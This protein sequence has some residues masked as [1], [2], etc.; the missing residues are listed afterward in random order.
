MS[1]VVTAET[2][3][4]RDHEPVASN[5][6][7]KVQL[8]RGLMWWSSYLLATCLFVIL[9]L[10]A[11]LRIAYADPDHYWHNRFLFISPNAYRNFDDNFWTYRPDVTIREVGIYGVAALFSTKPKILVEYDCRMRSNNLGLLQADNIQRGTV[12][13]VVMGD[14]FAAGQGGCP[15]FDRLQARRKS[16]RLINA[17]LPGTGFG[18]WVR[19]L[20]YLRGESVTVQRILVIAISSDFSRGIWVWPKPQ[21]ECL[22]QVL[23]PEDDQP[24][25]WL[26]VEDQE[27]HFRLIERSAARFS[28]RFA[29]S[30]RAKAWKEYLRQEFYLAKFVARAVDNVREHGA[31]LRNRE[32][33]S[34]ADRAL[35]GFKSLGIPL[36]VMLVSQRDEVGPFGNRQALN[37]AMGVL[38]THGV[39]HSWCRLSKGHFLPFDGHPNSTGYDYLSGC[40]DQILDTLN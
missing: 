12:A 14:S 39:T 2:R 40:V 6:R 31:T 22:A 37:A 27:S 1:V 32:T 17:A 36:H 7:V 13:T 16:D 38:K 21:L 33:F 8:R 19:L 25:L 3:A 24:G 18:H 10:E 5:M 15:W 9:G 30:S 23:C 20:E 35:E 26:P 11:L 28:A 34:E 4:I 29:Y